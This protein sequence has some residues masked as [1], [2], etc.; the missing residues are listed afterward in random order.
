[1]ADV[2]LDTNVLLRHVLADHTEQ[3]PRATAFLQ[4]VEQ[5]EIRVHLTDFVILETV[6]TLEWSY[7]RSK[8]LIRAALLP[9]IDLPSVAL[10]GK[11]R[12]PQVFDFYVDLNL[13]FADAYHA[14]VLLQLG[15]DE[16]LSFDHR[17]DR[18]PGITRV[19]P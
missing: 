4:R 2:F 6:F 18:V 7:R 12:F 10:P 1:M 16:V 14:A 13:S 5:G 8:D 3:S 15:V 19:E 17:F 9:L 11:R